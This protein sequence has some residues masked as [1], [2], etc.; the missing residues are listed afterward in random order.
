MG[1]NTAI[2]CVRCGRPLHNGLDTWGHPTEPM[3]E[4]CWS[5][6]QSEYY[7][8]WMKEKD[9][10]VK[11]AD[12]R[13]EMRALQDKKR[14]IVRLVEQAQF[15]ARRSKDKLARRQAELDELEQ[16]IDVQASIIADLREA[17]P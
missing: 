17:T 3:C 6:K 12:C 8:E 5:I 11:L 13:A 15:D 4:E 16:E 10:Q 9:R 14:R 2:E 1:A 7:H